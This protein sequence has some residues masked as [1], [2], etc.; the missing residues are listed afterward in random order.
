MSNWI[1]KEDKVYILSGND[2]GKTGIVLGVKDDR[3]LVQGI[4]IKKKHVKKTQQAQTSQIIS[5]EKPIHI[6]NVA[7]CDK[8]DKKIKKLIVRKND[9]QNRE[10]VYIDGGKEVVYRTIRKSSK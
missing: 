5:I 1:K 2:K 8:D 7:L 9:N 4:N 3:V 10:L 6:S